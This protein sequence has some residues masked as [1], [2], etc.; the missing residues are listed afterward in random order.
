LNNTLFLDQIRQL[1]S[2]H[3]EK[4]SHYKKIVDTFFQSLSTF[5]DISQCPFIPV[6][7][8]KTLELLSISREDVYKRLESSGTTG[9]SSKIYLD[10]NTASSQSNALRTLFQKEFGVSRIPFA[11]LESK[12]AFA[13]KASMT[14]SDAAVIGFSRFSSKRLFLLN[15]KGEL[16]WSTLAHFVNSS[17]DKIILFGFTSVLWNHLVDKRKQLIEFAS[18]KIVVLHGGGWK[19]MESR[20]ISR[21]EFNK[22]I[23][24]ATGATRVIDYYGM[25]EQTGSIF[26]ECFMGRFHVSEFA[27]VIVRDTE[28]F[29]VVEN[30]S[31]GLI[32]VISNI[33]I[34][35]PGHS[36]L[37]EDIGVILGEEGC[38]CGK[39]SRYFR[40]LGR[41]PK[42]EI[43]GCSDAN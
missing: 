41:L 28:T 27:H 12:E 35:Y 22:Q 30:G 26:F 8:F 31:T 37:T 18:G 5:D 9:L 19:K 7:L 43:R 6:R 25:A 34:S 20:G 42:A 38:P 10:R 3:Y 4:S 14:A 23:C 15:D 29:S 16:D 2:L 39:N 1:H 21:D 24:I 13:R 11:F 36:I 33:P 17:E 40:V 32:Q